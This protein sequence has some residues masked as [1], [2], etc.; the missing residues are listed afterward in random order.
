MYSSDPV[1]SLVQSFRLGP[2]AI[3]PFGLCLLAFSFTGCGDA[4]EG[5]ASGASTGTQVNE[6]TGV[7]A[8]GSRQAVVERPEETQ[9]LPSQSEPSDASRLDIAVTSNSR[10]LADVADD[11]A[12]LDPRKDGWVT[13]VI[14]EAVGR[15]LSSLGDWIEGNALDQEALSDMIE[16]DFRSTPLRPRQLET[17]YRD[18][19]FVVQRSPLDLG[20]EE[21]TEPGAAGLLG[22]LREF[23]IP[24]ELLGPSS[25]SEASIGTETHFKIVGVTVDQMVSYTRVLVEFEHWSPRGRLQQNAV[26]SCRWH[27][28]KQRGGLPLLAEIELL[29]YD[30]VWT[31]GVEEP[32]FTDVTEAVLGANP[33]YQQQLKYGVDH[34]RERLDWRFTQEVTGPHGLAVGDVNG[35]HLDDLFVCETGGLPNRLYVQLEDGTLK[36]VSAEAGVDYLEPAASALLLD[37]DNDGD[38][39]LVMSSGRNLLFLQNDGAARFSRQLIHRSESVARSLTAV[40]YDLDGRLDLYV[41]GYFSISGHSSGIGRPMPYH[42][43][44]NGVR[45][46]LLRNSGAWQFEDVTQQVGLE[47]NNERFS[48]AAAWEDYDRDGDLDLYVANDFGRNNLFRNDGGT[49]TDVAAEAG[50]EDVSAGMSVSW[51]D[52]NRDGFPDLYVGNMYSSAGNRVAF[53]RN[54]RSNESESARNLFQRHARG[55][56]LFENAGDGSFRD[57]SI[58]AGVT[59][60]RWAWSSNFADINN[61]GWDDLIVANGLVT[62]PDDTGDL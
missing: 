62:S 29:D 4:P 7:V 1:V 38:Q 5:E 44:N 19:T 43:A 39:D 32:L 28:A 52:Y 37:L 31:E 27:P 46:Y 14:S 35:D 54:Y 6:Q 11:L 45:N 36:D 30:S 17:H 2:K 61:D 21:K 23:V 18:A 8:Q 13:E 12:H 50:V 15:R 55:N 41:C 33:S 16:V 34:W 48:Y 25:D 3:V 58:D 20:S 40:D 10:H 9:S 59:M 22:A 24:K 26:W 57:V 49:F 42:D 60:G 51:G 47:Q 56:S 53:Q